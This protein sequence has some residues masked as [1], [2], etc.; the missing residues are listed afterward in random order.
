MKNE[1][2][3]F[4]VYFVQWNTPKRVVAYDIR[5]AYIKG[6]VLGMKKDINCSVHL[7]IDTNGNKWSVRENF[8]IKKLIHYFKI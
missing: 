6:I 1:K 5:H 8:E 4:Y 2:P 7:I 3:I